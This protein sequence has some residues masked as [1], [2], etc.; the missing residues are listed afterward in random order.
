MKNIINLLF[1][2]IVLSSV[3]NLA[4]S[5]EKS[6]SKKGTLIITV[7]G[8][9]NDEGAAMIGLYNSEEGYTETGKNYKGHSAEIKDS[10]VVWTI[11]DIPFGE[12]A[13]KLYHDE[14]S[15]E[16]MDR[17]MLG[18]PTE[19]YGFS[20]NAGGAFGPADY[21]DAKFKFTTSGQKHEINLD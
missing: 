14:N 19:D 1:V 13:V 2:L 5:T 10:K 9:E 4:Q 20:N 16:K 15:N 8:F 12:Y 17:N 21:E 6:E 11:E 3:N 7:T 18:I